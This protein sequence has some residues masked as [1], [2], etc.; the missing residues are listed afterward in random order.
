MKSLPNLFK[1]IELT[2]GQTQYGYLLSGIPRSQL[3]G[4]GDHHYLVTFMGWQ[5]ATHLKKAGASIDV[6]KVVEFCLI[7]DIG[8]LMGGDI[9]AP[10]ASFNK[11]A[12]KFAKAFEEENQKYVAKFFGNEADRFRKMGKEILNAKTDE[13]LIAKVADYVECTNY[14]VYVGHFRKADKEFNP[15]KIGSF[16]ARIK[17]SIAKQLLNEFLIDWL[18]TV[19]DSNYIEVL[20]THG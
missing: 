7:H 19:E 8:E 13:A 17:D 2:R 6:L 1:L 10:Y 12:R 11:R 5:L 3:S 14:K 9:S 16:I 15:E 4:L 18:K 20:K